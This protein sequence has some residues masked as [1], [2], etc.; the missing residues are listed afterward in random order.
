MRRFTRPIS[1]PV[2]TRGSLSPPLPPPCL[3][4]TSVRYKYI[5][6]HKNLSCG[7]REKVI[8]HTKTQVV[9]GNYLYILVCYFFVWCICLFLLDIK[10]ELIRYSQMRVYW[11][12]LRGK[13]KTRCF[14]AFGF[15]LFCFFISCDAICTG[16]V[17]IFS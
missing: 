1:S 12:Y 10:L 17:T 13:G 11:S 3:N 6:K 14:V 15:V 5:S 16:N 9:S 4:V 7:F 8:N 2:S